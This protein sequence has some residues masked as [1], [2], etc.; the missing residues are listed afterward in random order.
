MIAESMKEQPPVVPV[1]PPPP[2]RERPA[3]P[4]PR[5]RGPPAK[6]YQP[7]S[8]SSRPRGAAVEEEGQGHHRI[9]KVSN[10]TAADHSLF[11]ITHVFD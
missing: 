8:S 2:R 6:N 4:H 5:T 11:A 9:S 7:S 10:R 1:L 3:V